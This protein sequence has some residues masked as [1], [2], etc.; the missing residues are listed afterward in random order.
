MVR[1]YKQEPFIVEKVWGGQKLAY[2]SD[3]SDGPVGETWEVST[4]GEGESRV[5]GVELSKVIGEQI[6]LMVKLIDTSDNLSVQVHPD[7]QMALKEEGSVG[8]TECWYI[9]DSDENAMIY[10]GL[11]AGVTKEKLRDTI[12][13]GE[14]VVQH[15][16]SIAAK[17]GRFF[18]VPAGQVH[19][20][21]K[22][23]TLLE[24]QQSSGITYRLWDWNRLGLDGNPR[25]LHIEKGLRSIK[26]K[27]CEYFDFQWNKNERIKTLLKNQYFTV[28]YCELD[29]GL[30]IQLES[31]FKYLAVTCIEGELAIQENSDVIVLSKWETAL[32]NSNS[33]EKIEIKSNEKSKFMVSNEN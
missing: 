13:S 30:N 6:G 10:L 25:E 31:G 26:K 21:G 22:G 17:P 32:I 7:D 16:N 20:I 14:P 24:I 2:K 28:R 15:L 1:I 18:S 12:E 11:K 33:T 4:L 9:L 19:A 27:E 5:Q 23:V 8:K 3:G 29:L